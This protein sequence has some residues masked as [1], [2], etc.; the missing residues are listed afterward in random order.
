M[1]EIDS[2]V[3]FTYLLPFLV[4]LTADPLPKSLLDP[5]E[6]L[7]F[8][9]EF[10]PVLGLLSLAV[11]LPLVLARLYVP[12]RLVSPKFLVDDCCTGLGAMTD[13]LALTGALNPDFTVYPLGLRV[14]PVV[15]NFAALG[16]CTMGDDGLDITF[17]TV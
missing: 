15:F 10:V 13:P 2:F 7:L 17:L 9:V 11:T 1:F 4:S 8:I 12:D 5:N 3:V 6:G 16:F 14:E